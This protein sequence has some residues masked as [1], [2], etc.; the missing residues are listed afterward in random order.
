MM[1]SNSPPP[2]APMVSA[3]RAVALASHSSRRTRRSSPPRP[4]KGSPS[5]T[6]TP[7][8]ERHARGGIRCPMGRRRAMIVR[9]ERPRSAPSSEGAAVKKRLFVAVLIVAVAVPLAVLAF[10]P[11]PDADAKSLD[12]KTYNGYAEAR[13][14]GLKG[15]ASF[16]TFTDRAALLKTFSPVLTPRGK[17]DVVP[18]D[19]FDKQLF[20]AV[21]K[22]D[23]V[24]WDY[25][26]EKVTANG[27]TLTV[28][29]RTSE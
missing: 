17:P 8:R 15:E 9:V 5:M 10:A 12:Y 16:L 26:V 14:S 23:R 20:V 7:T 25:K 29:Y 24:L 1:P 21:I 28:S 2:C 3:G 27:D 18:A 13:D 11:A 19:A 6:P 22:R 4:R